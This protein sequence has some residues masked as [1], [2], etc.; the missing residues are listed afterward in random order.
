[1][2]II[3]LVFLGLCF[4]SF[5]TASVW[6]LKHRD[7]SIVTGRS[8]C[9]NC[10]HVLGP[11]DLIPLISWLTLRGKCRY[12]HKPISWQY[13]AIEAVTV[14]LFVFSYVF[15][16]ETFHGAG[17]FNFIVWLMLIVGFVVLSVYDL[18][19]HILP[20]ILVYITI[21]LALV[22]VLTDVIIFNKNYGFLL[23]PLW[24][25][26]IIAGV[27]YVLFQ[28][29]KGKW[30]GG[31]DVKLGICLGLLSFGPLSSLFTLFV[32]SSSG[33]IVSIALLLTQKANRKSQIPFG[34]F[35][36]IGAVICELFGQSVVNYLKNHVS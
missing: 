2:V 5:A 34:P 1:M 14:A 3:I 12:C 36:I 24:G 21:A 9:P 28:V 22:K 35:L 26:L 4:G 30:I 32:A 16:P 19:W 29:S 27:F 20:N 7:M 10:R 31:G 33:S 18:R 6:R 15:W 23:N 25:V 17:L 11:L 13:P 8:V